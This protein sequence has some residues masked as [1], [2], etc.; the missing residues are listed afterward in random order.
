MKKI[1]VSVVAL[2]L[3][4]GVG[5]S[6]AFATAKMLNGEPLYK[7]APVPD[8]FV[9]T[10]GVLAPLV[11]EKGRLVGYA[12]FEMQLEVPAEKG[13]LVADTV[14][15]LLNAINMRTYRTPLAAGPNGQIPRLDAFRKVVVDA[16]TEVY[17][18]GVVRRVA[19]VKAAPV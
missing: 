17:G 13:K 18:K 14:P 12:T 6:A 5:G 10:G 11:D 16:A 7:P 4:V 1:F 2:V 8:M 19:V 9:P 15:V 3:G